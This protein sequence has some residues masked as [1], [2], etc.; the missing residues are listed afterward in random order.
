MST[1]RDLFSDEIDVSNVSVCGLDSSGKTTIINF[2]IH[3][4]FKKTIPTMGQNRDTFK[5][6][7]KKINFIDLGG[8][9][10]FRS[11]WTGINAKADALIYV[12]D[13]TDIER[14]DES[15][16]IFSQI[17]NNQI[18]LHIPIMIL[19]NKIDLANRITKA[20]LIQHFELDSLS[21]ELKW[22]CY[23]TSAKSG[24][25]MIDAF[26]NFVQNLN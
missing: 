14:L 3:G 17:I 7:N 24:E 22:I 13:G 9:P 6:M 23:E 12:V 25:G 19:L 18:Q 8:Q 16:E 10:S 11:I 1:Y 21:N 15:K 26:S 4:K 5:L 20:E 2:I